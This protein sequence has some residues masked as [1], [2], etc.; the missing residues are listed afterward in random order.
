MPEASRPG[1]RTGQPPRADARR[2]RERLLEAAEE[3]FAAAGASAATEEIARRAGV[4]IGT[5]FRHFPTKAALVE[6]VVL[7]RVG[8]LAEEAEALAAGGAPAT[9]FFAF[10]RH[11][12][13]EAAAKRAYA[14]LL[15]D[16]PVDIG[17]AAP[18]LRRR[19]HEGVGALL[20][21]AQGAGAVR[22]DIGVPEVMALLA[23]AVRATEHA[24]QDG[25]LRERTLG[26]VLDGLRPPGRR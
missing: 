3:V 15:A 24:G 18:S 6:A 14:D 7:A 25:D 16:G 19:L 2:N 21:H 11:A 26:V 23:G 10:F 9:A 17:R 4:G 20:T 13:G 8:R 5:L 12:V 22:D 1:A